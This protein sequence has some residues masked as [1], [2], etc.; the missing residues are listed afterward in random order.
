MSVVEWKLASL[1]QGGVQGRSGGQDRRVT[2]VLSCR[3]CEPQARALRLLNDGKQLEA[4]NDRLSFAS[5]SPP[6]P[7]CLLLPPSVSG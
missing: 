3:A 1:E 6:T 2:K 5:F 4:L 7:N